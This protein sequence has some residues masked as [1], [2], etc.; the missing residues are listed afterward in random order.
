M[1]AA[2]LADMAGLRV[3]ICTVG[4]DGGGAHPHGHEGGAKMHG[5]TKQ[6][7]KANRHSD[8]HVTKQELKAQI[9][10]SAVVIVVL[11]ADFVAQTED[12]YPR[13]SHSALLAYSER[14]EARA[15]L[16]H[17]A[18]WH[19]LANVMFVQLGEHV[20][21]AAVLVK[22]ALAAT[23]HGPWAI[24]STGA[25]SSRPTLRLP[26]PLVHRDG[27]SHQPPTSSSP[28]TDATAVPMSHAKTAFLE[29]FG[30]H[31]WWNQSVDVRS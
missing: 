30:R 14:S 25:S 15:C 2:W 26:S 18:F 11:S 16:E 7:L 31:L 8:P 28:G 3:S 9:E 4:A 13:P 23:T 6:E 21:W 20:S 19:G 12:R 5:I 29:A 10:G 22:A 1:I 17:A 24:S 27:A